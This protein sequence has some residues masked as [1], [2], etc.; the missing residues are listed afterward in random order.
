[1]KT[2]FMVLT[3]SA[4]G[5][6]S[7]SAGV[8]STQD[9]E[10]PINCELAAVQKVS[11][12]LNKVGSDDTVLFPYDHGQCYYYYYEEE[13]EANVRAKIPEEDDPEI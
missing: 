11:A 10:I 2:L 4:L 12:H 13:E 6:A 1:M 3:L 5:M 8:V 7:A 9:I